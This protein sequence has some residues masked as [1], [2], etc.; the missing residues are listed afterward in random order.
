M[1]THPVI[2]ALETSGPLCSVAL[3]RQDGQLFTEEKIGE[4]IHG[5]EITLMI[6]RVLSE[7]GVEPSHLNGVAVSSGPGSFTGL[8][9]GLSTAK[10]L[11]MALN[12]PLLQPSTLEGLAKEARMR[13]TH[14]GPVLAVVK[15]RVGEWYSALYLEDNIRGVEARSITELSE[16]IQ[17]VKDTVLLTGPDIQ[18]LIV[19]MPVLEMS[20]LEIPLSSKW[21]LQLGIEEYHSGRFANLMLAEPNYIKPV[22]ITRPSIL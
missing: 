3:M 6:L 17:S 22:R 5:E 13:A 20:V 21:V 7:A 12:I 10:G 16:L 9:V 18:S 4:R 8:R 19:E 2:L 11:C 15:A 14:S 1:N